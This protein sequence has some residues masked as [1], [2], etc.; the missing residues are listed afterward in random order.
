MLPR[1][2]SALLVLTALPLAAAETAPLSS[3]LASL[4][5]AL[6]FDPRLS[7]DRTMSCASCHDPSRAFTD[8]RDNGVGGAA[9]LGNDGKTLG[10]RNAP[11]LTYVSLVPAFA[12]R[13]DGSYAGGL[14][15][16]GRA[17]TLAVQASQPITSANEMA[18][19]SAAVVRDRVRENAVYVDAFTALLGDQALATP[20]DAL[21]SVA[22]AIAAFES[23]R[24]FSSFDSRY[25]RYLRG[26]AS[27]TSEEELGR[28]LF[29]S[30]LSN[31]SQCH[32]IDQRENR[33]RETFTNFE[34]HNIGVPPNQRLRAANGSG[35]DHVDPGLAGN[36]LVSGREQ[37]GK[38]RVPSLRNVAVTAPYMHNGVFAELR[39]AIL[40][41]NRF[42][43][44][45][46]ASRTNPETGE[47]WG[48]A[49]LA[50]TVAHDLLAIGQPLS[51]RRVRQIEAFLKTL[52]DQRYEHLL[53]R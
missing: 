41:Y 20:D 40:F 49:E 17:A 46:P 32:V 37:E 50:A 14:F 44:D 30:P 33:A 48:E 24:E 8:G 19:P 21:A 34:Y 27:L 3:D 2:I 31:C 29:F 4:G 43:V 18:M 16:D 42:L 53:E 45:N 38:V 26:E 36:P 1:I 10:D 5:R 7:N 22:E 51:E 23:S 15:H 47:P 11:M 28:S 39:T 13:D 12:R 52:T 9:S 25:D 6:F 35:P